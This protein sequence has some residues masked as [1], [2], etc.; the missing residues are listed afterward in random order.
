MPGRLSERPGLAP[1][2][3]AAV[4]E[5]RVAGE[6]GLRPE[7]QALHHAGAVAFDERVGVGQQVE[8]LRRRTGRFQVDGQGVLAGIQRVLAAPGEAARQL[9]RL[10]PLD[11]R[12]ARTHLHEHV[13]RQRAGPDAF[14]LDH[15]QA[16]QRWG[17]GVSR[18]GSR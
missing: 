4:H 2:R 8:H 13:A 1:A 15:V 16:G 3:H 18:A 10:R 9:V 6:A 17:H 11:Q 12:D 7:A 14:E 5:A